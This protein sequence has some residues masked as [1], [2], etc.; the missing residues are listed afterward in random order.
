MTSTSPIPFRHIAI[1]GGGTMGQSV[2]AWL[3]LQNLEVTLID[4]NAT[5]IEEAESNIRQFLQQRHDRGNLSHS[6]I[7]QIQGSLHTKLD[8]KKLEHIELAI[9]CVTEDMAIK[10]NVLIKMEQALS[11]KAIISSNTSS[12]EISRLADTLDMPGRFMGT[13]FFYPVFVNPILEVIRGRKTDPILARKVREAFDH[14][15]KTAIAAQDSPGFVVNRFFSPYINTAHW[16]MESMGVSGATI[17]EIGIKLFQ[18]RQGPLEVCNW[19]GGDFCYETQVNIG[20]LGSFYRPTK[21]LRRHAMAKQPIRLGDV[22]ELSE[23]QYQHIR[24]TLLGSVF[25]SCLQLLDE[26]VGS[27]TDIDLAAKLGLRFDIPPCALMD[28]LGKDEVGRI[29]QPIIDR[30]G[31]GVPTSLEQ[32]GILCRNHDSA[33]LPS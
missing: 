25:F 20:R 9:E 28:Q 13:H 16:L 6:D 29:I 18:S 23:T 8:W 7:E 5:L 32:T 14:L 11:Q 2:A 24:D 21:A 10:R 12:L 31:E 22:Q 19:I 33:T 1:I 17:D 4:A 27:A 26:H 15:G 3:L 30:H